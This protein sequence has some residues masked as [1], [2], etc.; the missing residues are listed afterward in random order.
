[1]HAES[2]PL[3]GKI[4]KIKPEVTHFQQPEFGGMD[5][6]IEDWWDKLTGR[7]WMVSDGNPAALVYAMRT[8]VKTPIDDEVVYG[9]GTGRFA[10][11]HLVHVSELDVSDPRDPEERS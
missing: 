11:G 3:A 10:L 7:S 2:H 6:V 4:V 9:K 1:M 8:A 5:F